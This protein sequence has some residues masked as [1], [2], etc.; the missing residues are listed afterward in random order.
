MKTTTTTTKCGKCDGKGVIRAYMHLDGG[1]CFGCGGAGVV[2]AKAVAAPLEMSAAYI[3]R[4]EKELMTRL[5]NARS[6]GAGWALDG[7]HGW[8][9]GRDL[10]GWI[11]A[12]PSYR[13]ARCL[14]AFAAA[15]SPADM[16]EIERW[17]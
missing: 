3:A 12:L 16:A 17:V 9:S 15:L 6:Y 7:E 11:Q 14:A 10:A 8:T 1:K 5:R 4:V 2:K 13:H